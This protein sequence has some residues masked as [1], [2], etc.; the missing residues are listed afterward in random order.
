[1]MK[2]LGY[3]HIEDAEILVE[4][5]QN[6]GIRAELKKPDFDG[7]TIPIVPDN[8][9][10]I[11]EI[12]KLFDRKPIGQP[13]YFEIFVPDTEFI[14]AESIRKDENILTI[15]EGLN[16][17]PIPQKSL[18]TLLEIGKAGRLFSALASGS[19]AKGRGEA[20]MGVAEWWQM[21]RIIFHPDT[22]KYFQKSLGRKIWLI[23]L[24]GSGILLLISWLYFGI[25]RSIPFNF[26]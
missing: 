26:G 12:R 1:M 2:L 22:L 21:I 4:K 13:G 11:F 14:E 25:Y 24:L 9:S 8:D 20:E 15:Q 6:K 3:F 10:S 18:N 19:T 5:L 17:I 23:L 16:Q 7:K